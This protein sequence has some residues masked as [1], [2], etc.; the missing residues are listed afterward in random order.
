MSSTSFK[1]PPALSKEN[2]YESCRR[3]IAI[4]QRVT[5]IPAKKQAMAVSLSLT[6]KYREV[7]TNIPIETLDSENGMVELLKVLDENFQKENVD[8]IYERYSNFESF[9]RGDLTMS[10]FIIEF[11][12]LYNRLADSGLKFPEELKGC[13]LLDFASLEGTQRQMVLTAVVSLKYD[14]VKKVLRR[15]FGGVSV[16][17]STS[18][19]VK[20]EAFVASKRP[21]SSARQKGKKLNPKNAFGK[22]TKCACCGSLYHW[23]RDCPEK[24]TPPQRKQK[25]EEEAFESQ[26]EID[27]QSMVTFALAADCKLLDECWNSGII[28]TACT[29]SICGAVWFEHFVQS[30][31][32][33]HKDFETC[34]SSTEV[35]FGN[36]KRQSAIMKA[37]LPIV[38][39]GEICT[40]QVDVLEGNLP[41][42]I[43]KSALKRA[44]F[45]LNTKNDSA[46]FFGRHIPLRTTS[47]GHYIIPLLPK[48]YEKPV[49][50]SMAL[51]VQ[52]RE[53]MLLKQDIMKLHR[54]F[55]HCSS[56]ALRRLLK[57]GS[58]NFE[59]RLI[60]C[61]EQCQVCSKQKKPDRRPIVCLP[62]SDNFN[63]VLALDLS[64]IS[65]DMWFLHITCTFSRYSVAIIMKDKTPKSIIDGFF[66]H[67]V[68][69]FGAPEKAFLTDNGREFNNEQFRS[70]L[71]L[72]LDPTRDCQVYW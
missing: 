7:A 42:L 2:T 71:R 29:N 25:N 31:S 65:S 39:C 3:E 67:W 37:K 11:E 21:F 8:S 12:R 6:G 34:D 19:E 50:P 14:D 53:G 1:N 4:W 33:G 35:M 62:V 40:I 56:S 69:V 52:K 63:Q 23:V 44:N 9:R 15:V 57:N 5:E 28:D 60:A 36:L 49:G 66:N 64:Y 16:G 32:E 68:A 13:K 47:S 54:Q 51:M 70:L 58:F 10:D 46:T 20:S 30:L 45:S 17:A 41:L 48:S 72:L 27:G 55:G 38:I 22:V 59:E 18:Y 61:V 26:A 24:E 43:S